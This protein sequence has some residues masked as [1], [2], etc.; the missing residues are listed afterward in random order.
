MHQYEIK[1]YCPTDISKRA[2]LAIY[3][4]GRRYREY[5]GQKI[6]VNLKPNRA[7]SAK[8]RRALLGKLEFEFRKKLDDGSYQKLLNKSN[9]HDNADTLSLEE[10]FNNALNQK[11]TSNLSN[12]Y[13]ND[14]EKLCQDF[15]SFLK[16]D[17]RDGGFKHLKAPRIQQYLDN[18]RKTP[19]HYMNK[20]RHMSALIGVIKRMYDFNVDPM[21]KV[22][23]IKTKAT[24]HKIY[25]QDQLRDVLAYLKV[26]HENMYLCCL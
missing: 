13:I 20:W 3:I 21:R 12:R 17:E 11:K 14:L 8:E 25:T 5:N 6:A 16:K 9:A 10:L 2:Y 7:K 23:K 4:A 24:L 1:C 22:S 15:L 26:N 18:F 19:Q